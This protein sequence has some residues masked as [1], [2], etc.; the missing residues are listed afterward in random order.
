MRL[1]L[2]NCLLTT[3]V[4]VSQ[5]KGYTILTVHENIDPGNSLHEP[6]LLHMVVL[7]E[8][9]SP[10]DGHVVFIAIL[11][12]KVNRHSAFGVLLFKLSKS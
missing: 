4:S 12:N 2:E 5:E 1:V 11:Y 8:K 9:L 7:D 3:N 10:N 6:L